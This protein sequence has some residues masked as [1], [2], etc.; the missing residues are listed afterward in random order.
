MGLP[1]A[2]QLTPRNA[3]P[4]LIGI[5][6]SPRRVCVSS[7]NHP[8]V[9]PL[10]DMELDT[11]FQRLIGERDP[12]IAAHPDKAGSPFPRSSSPKQ[13]GGTWIT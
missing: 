4:G 10:S 12:E 3:T 11:R 7:S 6:R 1:Y 13:L 2:D 9:S 5:Y 8:G